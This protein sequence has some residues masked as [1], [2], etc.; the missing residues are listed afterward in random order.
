[1]RMSSGLFGPSLR[2][3]RTA[4]AIPLAATWADTADPDALRKENPAAL[5]HTVG[6]LRAFLERELELRSAAI[7]DARAKFSK[8]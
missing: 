3:V 4:G 1:M 6:E 7:S 2:P 5:F 8:I